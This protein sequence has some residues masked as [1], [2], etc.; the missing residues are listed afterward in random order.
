[1]DKSI[2]KGLRAA[3]KTS[4]GGLGFVQRKIAYERA[5][6]VILISILLLILLGSRLISFINSTGGARVSNLSSEEDLRRYYSSGQYDSNFILSHSSI[7]LDGEISIVTTK[8]HELILIFNAGA[9]GLPLPSTQ[10]TNRYKARLLV[11]DEYAVVLLVHHDLYDTVDFS[12]GVLRV[13]NDNIELSHEVIDALKQESSGNLSAFSGLE[14]QN[15]SIY[16]LSYSPPGIA[17]AINGFW[18]VPVIA[19]LFILAVFLIYYEPIQKSSKLGRMI[20]ALGNY[21]EAVFKINNQA[22]AAILTGSEFFILKDFILLNQFYQHSAKRMHWTLVPIN[23]I[24]AFISSPDEYYPDEI[25]HIWF[26]HDGNTYQL[27]VYTEEN[28]Q[29]IVEHIESHIG[30]RV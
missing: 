5:P 25:F 26:Y 12:S 30:R 2:N 28:A 10:S 7:D 16:I 6:L 4:I 23:Q 19:G 9:T 15:K 22:T 29:R 14:S 13:N 11:G 18:G 8:E 17:D 27:S 1:M 24:T 20:Y 3:Q 21:D